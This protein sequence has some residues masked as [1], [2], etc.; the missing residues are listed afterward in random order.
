MTTATT[1][2]PAH[3]ASAHTHEAVSAASAVIR[4]RVDRAAAHEKVRTYAG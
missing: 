4:A 2:A 1:L 3:D